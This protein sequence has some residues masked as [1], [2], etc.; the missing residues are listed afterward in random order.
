MNISAESLLNM[1]TPIPVD[2]ER[3]LFAYN[4]LQSRHSNSLDASVYLGMFATAYKDEHINPVVLTNLCFVL[5]TLYGVD[6]YEL[7]QFKGR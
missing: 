4:L 1:A 2:Q 7:L 5:S 6:F 3:I